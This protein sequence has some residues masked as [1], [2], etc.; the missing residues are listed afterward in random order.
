MILNFFFQLCVIYM[1]Y[2][3]A[4]FAKCVVTYVQDGMCILRTADVIKRT[5]VIA[6]N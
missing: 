1:E 3:N 6:F 5:S 2:F 4:S